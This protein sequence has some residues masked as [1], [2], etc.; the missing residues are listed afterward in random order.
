MKKVLQHIETLLR[1]HDYVIVPGLGGFVYQFHSA[2]IDQ[3]H[4]EPPF[5]SISFNPLM[6]IP[7]GLLTIEYSR[8]ENVSFRA[9]S[10]LIADEIDSVNV[11]LNQNQS[12][13]FGNLGFLTKNNEGKLIF[14]PSKNNGLIPANFG[15]ETVHVSRMQTK[16][17]QRR[18]ISF[19]LPPAR[20]ITRYAA[21]GA[22]LVGL[23]LFTPEIENS[24]KNQ[25]NL[26]PSDQITPIREGKGN[27]NVKSPEM[28][29]H[30]E[31]I[32]GE[33]LEIRPIVPLNHHVI[34]S[35]MASQAD[36]DE[37]CNRLKD[38]DYS[39]A[40]VLPPIKTYRVAIESFET[41]DEAIQFM[42]QLRISTP[43]FS[44]A[45]VLSDPKQ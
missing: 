33:Q 18:V 14:S 15:L 17:E 16:I 6:N 5:V 4:I 30:Q 45:W 7:D 28:M 36:A 34:V 20:K 9:A 43:Q 25:A 38:M 10:A 8:K 40:H 2:V 29:T 27:G 3:N 24:S 12:I 39:T 23:F 1:R 41:K 42:R 26:F 13:E 32:A 19:T 37:L 31:S 21:I 44:D 11:A 22:V 35:C